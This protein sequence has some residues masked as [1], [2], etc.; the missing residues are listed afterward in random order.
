MTYRIEYCHPAY[1][2]KP[3]TPYH[4]ML[5]EADA[6]QVLTELTLHF[7]KT[8]WRMM[9]ERSEAELRTKTV[10]EFQNLRSWQAGL[11]LDIPLPG[12]DCQQLTPLEASLGL[13]FC[14]SQTSPFANHVHRNNGAQATADRNGR[15]VLRIG[16]GR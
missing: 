4:R 5:S 6:R 9:A 10:T 2:W 7:L 1:G 12:V 16:A 8:R 14:K 13:A 3:Y 15:L 11:G